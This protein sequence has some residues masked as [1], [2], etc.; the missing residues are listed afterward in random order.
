MFIPHGDSSEQGTVRSLAES[1]PICVT[2]RDSKREVRRRDIIF[3]I[4]DAF[5]LSD[6]S[7]TV[8]IKHEAI[9]ATVSTD[10]PTG[11]IERN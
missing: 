3:G 11:S 8:I 7:P 4:A 1:I 6:S 9:L 10:Q 5:S 2:G